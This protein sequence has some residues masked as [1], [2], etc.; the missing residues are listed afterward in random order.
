MTAPWHVSDTL[1]HRYAAGAAP[2]TDA[3]SLE[4]HVE[5]CGSCATRV[6]AAVR[7]GTAGPALAAIR[8][9]LL[10][11]LG[12]VPAGADTIAPATRGRGHEP[13]AH[14]PHTA[15]STTHPQAGT[16][17]PATHGETAATRGR[18]HE[19]VT[20]PPHTAA[21]TTHPQAGAAAPDRPELGAAAAAVHAA[22][23]GTAATRG[24]GKPGSHPGPAPVAASPAR[25]GPARA[26]LAAGP[27]RIAVA[28]PLGRWARIWWAAGPALRGSWIVAVALV[29]GGAFA[30]AHAA[31]FRGARSWLLAVS[32]LLPLA[33]VAVSYGRHADPLYE[34]TA[35]TPSGG[36]RLLLTRTAAVLGVCVPLLTAGGALLP[37]AAGTPGAAAWLLPGLALTLATLALGSFVGCRAAAATLGGGWLLA[38]TGPLLGPQGQGAAGVARYFAGPAVQGAWAAAALVCAALLALRRRSFDHLETR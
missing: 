16:P 17:A 8:A 12:H 33:G 14:P 25:P 19:P 2:E 20:H 4:K 28:H 26:G 34:I 30:L 6:S 36:L 27:G 38:V 3:W 13:V 24:R 18:G 35:A 23:A 10:A 1:A 5:S 29:L 11:S 15:A 7:A 32:P 31:G 9:D 37:P 22:P 21:S